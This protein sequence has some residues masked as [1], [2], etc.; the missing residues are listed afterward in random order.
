MWAIK[1][2][3]VWMICCMMGLWKICPSII[4]TSKCFL[5]DN[6]CV[7]YTVSIRNPIFSGFLFIWIYEL[8]VLKSQQ[9][10]PKSEKDWY[11]SVNIPKCYIWQNCRAIMHVLNFV[12][13]CIVYLKQLSLTWGQ[14]YSRSIMQLNNT[15][16][17]KQHKKWVM[18]NSRQTGAKIFY[19]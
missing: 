1:D 13:H 12:L 8:F 14:R 15:Y 18:E 17:Y 2:C 16:S 3:V 9:E 11:K 7:C 10:I 5:I 4:S 6:Q 19:K